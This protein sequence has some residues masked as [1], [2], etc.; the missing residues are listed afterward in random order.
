VKLYFLLARRVPPVPSP[1]VVEVAARLRARGFEIDSGTPEEMLVAGDRLAPA[2]DLYVLKSHTELA[3]SLAASLHMQGARVLNPVP[4][5]AAA[6]N[7]VLAV[8]RLRAAGVPVPRTFVTGDAG[9]LHH[10]LDE[11]GPLVVKPVRGYRGTGVHVVRSPHDLIALLPLDGPVMAQDLVDGPGEDLKVY[12]VGERVWAVRKPFSATSFSV[13]GRPVPVT[14]EV[15]E[16]ALRAGAVSGLGL[17][18]IDIIESPDGPVVVDLNAFP[19]YKGTEGV[20]GPMADYIAAYAA[21]RR[22]LVLP[23]LRSVPDAATLAAEPE[24]PAAV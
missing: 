19:G 2:H 9:R 10:L 22:E 6:H 14:P 7:K 23:P 24:L 15:E 18:G 20:A 8:Q 12:V 13:P 21:G 1:V 5:T 4:A 3:L 11:R 17:Y 16:I